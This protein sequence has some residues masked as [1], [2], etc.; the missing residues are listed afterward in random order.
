MVKK[1]FTQILFLSFLSIS[2]TLVFSLPAIKI[3]FEGPSRT[4]K[5]ALINFFEAKG[6]IAIPEVATMVIKE[7]LD[8]GE[9][10]P[11]IADPIKFQKT[12]IDKQIELEVV[13]KNI[14]EKQVTFLDRAMF[15]VQGYAQ[16]RGVKLPTE[17]L[18]AIKKHIK[19]AKYDLIFFPEALP[20]KKDEIRIESPEEVQDTWKAIWDVCVSFDLEPIIVPRF[21]KANSEEEEIL[22]RAQF[23]ANT[24][25][26]KL[27][28]LINI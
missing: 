12:I 26:E 25:Y 9:E 20:Y 3:V 15:S 14:D 21:L 10:H 16:Y 8:K 4:G 23:V 13:L 17:Y 7:A 11:A 2:S 27:G 1:Q 24:I 22:L 18:D 19:K 6:S 5:S 28:V